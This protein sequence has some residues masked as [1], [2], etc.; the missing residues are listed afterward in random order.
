MCIRSSYADL[1]AR[2]AALQLVPL[3][4]REVGVAGRTYDG[5]LVAC[6]G[7]TI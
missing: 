3:C 7:G 6:T 1:D 5:H 2:Q 4:L